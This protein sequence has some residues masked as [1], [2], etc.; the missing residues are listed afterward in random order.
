MSSEIGRVLGTMDAQPLDFWAAGFPSTA[1]WTN[2]WRGM[3]AR[4][5][6]VMSSW[7]S[8]AYFLWHTPS[9]LM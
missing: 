3:K 4:V 8:R 5:W 6:K 1:W 9:R 2:S 7:L